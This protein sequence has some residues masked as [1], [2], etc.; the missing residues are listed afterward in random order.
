MGGL[1]V[2]AFSLL[3]E[4]IVPNRLAGVLAGS[5]SVALASLLLTIVKRG[6]SPLPTLAIG[7]SIGAV[8]FVAYVLTLWFLT[9][10]LNPLPG[11]F[12]GWAAWVTVA[13]AG[14]WAVPP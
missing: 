2:V 1:L 6:P 12:L 9:T 4:V 14:V 7:M 11:A 13:A 8:A 3:A 10:R 5:P